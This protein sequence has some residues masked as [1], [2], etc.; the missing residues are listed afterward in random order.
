MFTKKEGGEKRKKATLGRSGPEKR[1]P[2]R[3]L[4][5]RKRAQT[6]RSESPWMGTDPRQSSLHMKR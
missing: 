1:P 3:A 5:R 2:A 6:S 4:E